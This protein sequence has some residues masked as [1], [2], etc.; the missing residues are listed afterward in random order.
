MEHVW[1]PLKSFKDDNQLR[2]TA[3]A[4]KHLNWSQDLLES[5]VRKKKQRNI[6]FRRIESILCKNLQGYYYGLRVCT[7]ASLNPTDIYEYSISI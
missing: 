6:V 2:T 3:A 5:I 1:E 7:L 4:R